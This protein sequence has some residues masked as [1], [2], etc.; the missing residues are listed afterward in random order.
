MHF[1]MEFVVT[2]ILNTLL[3]FILS[4]AVFI[5]LTGCSSTKSNVKGRSFEISSVTKN[6]IDLVTET[7]QQ[8]VFPALK[9]LAEKLYKRNP[10]E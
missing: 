3:P 7:H 9:E 8:V 4:I 2:L 1:L 10:R 6:D 5:C